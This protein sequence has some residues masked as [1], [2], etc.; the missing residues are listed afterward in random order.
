LFEIPERILGDLPFLILIDQGQTISLPSPFI[1]DIHPDIIKFG[2][3]P[4]K[5]IIHLVVVLAGF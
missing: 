2:N 3:F 5:G 4:L 1:T